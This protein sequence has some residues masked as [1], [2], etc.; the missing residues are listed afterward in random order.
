[1]FNQ[2]KRKL[3][4]LGLAAALSFN[5]SAGQSRGAGASFVFPAMTKWSSVYNKAT[6]NRISYQSIGSGGG[7][8]QAK[9]ISL[10]RLR[11]L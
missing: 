8:A 3:T 1:M 5:V 2:L 11:S 4:V 10:V 6:Q 9:V 7:I